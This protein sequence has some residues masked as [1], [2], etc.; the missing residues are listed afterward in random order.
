MPV[1][2]LRA[3]N[4]QTGAALP[5]PWPM[6]AKSKYA[7]RFYT[8]MYAM[9]AGSPGAG[10][11]ML[12][13]DMAIR[14]NVPTLYIS[15]DSDEV[16]MRVRAAAILSGHDQGTIRQ[17]LDYGMFKEVYGHYLAGL[18]IKFMFDPSEPSM[19]DI[20]NALEAFK[21]VEGEMPK[22][23]IIDNIMNMEI[24]G[25]NEWAGMRMAS[26]DLQFLSR[27]T[28]ACVVA[29]HH[30]SEQDPRWI[31]SAPPASAIQGKITQLP[32]MVL[33]V[34]SVDNQ[35]FVAVVKQRFGDRDPG[36]TNPFRFVTDFSRGKIWDQPMMGVPD[37]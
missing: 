30:T 23:I 18:P 35:M 17:V 12:A 37:V 10:K 34:A 28:R 9:I 24:D 20:F 3:A 2:L 16:T 27:K 25:N 26:K 36:A 6:L 32:S 19:D 31:T 13:L 1:P 8:P 5:D 21:E 33:T 15:A 22:L 7:V 11:T 4:H 29:L 14:M